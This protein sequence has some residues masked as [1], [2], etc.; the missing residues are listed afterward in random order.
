MS[1]PSSYPDCPFCEIVRRLNSPETKSHPYDEDSTTHIVLSN[2]YA[3]AFLDRLP[4]T[5]CHT[6][7]I[8]KKHYELLSDIPAL[9]AAELG[10][11]LPLVSRAVM[12]ISGADA[13]NVVQNNGIHSWDL[14][15]VGISAGQ[16]VPH[17]HFHVVPRY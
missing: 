8:P 11:V 6:L 3:V 4:L 5:K 2:P 14:V 7:I 13:F 12:K 15:D 9:E 10:R 16:V 17:A 1:T